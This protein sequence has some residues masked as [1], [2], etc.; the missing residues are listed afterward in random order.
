[1]GQI[2][3]TQRSQRDLQAIFDYIALDS[4]FYAHRSLRQLIAASRKLESFPL[5]GKPVTELPGRELREVVYRGYRLIYRIREDA[6][7]ILAVVD[8]R[9]DLPRLAAEEW[10]LD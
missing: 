1:M 5:C 3:W 4:A 2:R 8:G 9:R 7:E 10:D 6:V